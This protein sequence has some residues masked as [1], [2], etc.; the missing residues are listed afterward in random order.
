MVASVYGGGIYVSK[1]F[2]STWI[3]SSSSGLPTS[4]TWKGLAINYDGT[5]LVAVAGATG[6][7]KTTNF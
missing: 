4:A 5:Q 7:F 3:L 2:G 1:N 6:V